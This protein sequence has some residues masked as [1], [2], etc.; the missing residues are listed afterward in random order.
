MTFLGICV[1]LVGATVLGALILFFCGLERIVVLL[2][3]AL[4][5]EMLF[6]VAVVGFFDLPH[7]GYRI[8]RVSKAGVVL[9]A[10]NDIAFSCKGYCLNYRDSSQKD[11][12]LVVKSQVSAITDN[13]KVREIE[14]IMSLQIVDYPKALQLWLDDKQVDL[15]EGVPSS[16]EIEKGLASLVEYEL[17][18]FKNTNSIALSKL[19][20]PHDHTQNTVMQNM[21]N[22]A[23]AEKLLQKGFK[24]LKIEWVVN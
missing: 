14:I 6:F 16:K 23:M 7:V 2:L 11:E 17:Y 18:E 12:P 19:Y 15:A 13:P 20:N 3:A 5:M 22:E 4:A 10:D 21:I 8:A 1:L 24:I 9:D